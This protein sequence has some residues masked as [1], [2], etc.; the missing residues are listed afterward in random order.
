M[1]SK[2]CELNENNEDD[3]QDTL[4]E[5]PIINVPI[6]GACVANMIST[7]HNQDEY[8]DSVEV[9]CEERL[10]ITNQALEQVKLVFKMILKI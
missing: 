3:R 6:D 1:I 10:K 4:T 5:D 9:F 7:Q 2:E 8:C